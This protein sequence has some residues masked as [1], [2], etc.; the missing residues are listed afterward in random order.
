MSISIDIQ[1]DVALIRMDDGK[2]NVINFELMAALNDALDEAQSGA[3]AVVLAGRHD[4]FSGGFDLRAFATLDGGEIVRMLDSGAQLLLRLY[5]G[6]M[7]VVAACTGHAIAMGAFLLLACDTR[8]GT[9][10]DYK[11]GANET[12]NGMQLP[13]FALE[14][15]R[16]RIGLQYQT[17]AAIQAHIYDPA[18]AVQ[19]GYLDSL[20]VAEEVVEQAL[21]VAAQFATYP[22]HAYSYNKAALRKPTLEAIRSSI[23][24]HH[25]Q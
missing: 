9:Q 7:P 11:I 21:S 22:A 12:T 23:G 17:Q 13:I 6:P 14:M 19:V 1:N 3:K 8:I 18:G 2:A 10:G 16:A 4:R 5:G 15:M 25:G 24:R 20:T